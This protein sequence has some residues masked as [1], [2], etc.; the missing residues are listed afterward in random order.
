MQGIGGAE[1]YI[2][3]KKIN[4]SAKVIFIS[5]Y[6]EEKIDDLQND[7][8]VYWLDKP[9]EVKELSTTLKQCLQSS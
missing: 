5:G 8:N 1:A 4:P 2:E 9:F 6:S 7:P 3:I